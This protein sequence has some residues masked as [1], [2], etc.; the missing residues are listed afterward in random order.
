M[1]AIVSNCLLTESMVMSCFSLFR[2]CE[3]LVSIVVM[4]WYEVANDMNQYITKLV[5]ILKNQH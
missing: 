5:S 4:V 2:D 3:G 1:G